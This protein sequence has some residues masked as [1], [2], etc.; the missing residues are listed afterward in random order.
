MSRILGLDPGAK[1]IGVALSDPSGGIAQS[2][3]SVEKTRRASWVA[4]IEDLV[5]EYQVREVIVGLPLNMNGSEGPAAADARRLVRAL[6]N[7]LKVPVKVWDERLTTVAAK[8]MFQETGVKAQ[9][10]KKRLDGVAAALILQGYLYHR[11]K[12]ERDDKTI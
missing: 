6:K 4:E 7:R 8:R 5:T 2:L 3:K 1:R 11:A 10:A 12:I 9:R